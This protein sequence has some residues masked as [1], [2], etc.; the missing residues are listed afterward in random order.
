MIVRMEVFWDRT[1]NLLPPS[2]V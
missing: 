2:S 1:L